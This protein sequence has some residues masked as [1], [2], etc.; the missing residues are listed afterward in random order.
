ML[1]GVL[2]P[3]VGKRGGEVR[4]A[5]DPDGI[6]VAHV[7]P[8]HV[9]MTIAAFD[10]SLFDSYEVE[11][12]GVFAVETDRLARL[13]KVHRGRGVFA[14]T[15]GPKGELVCR[16][17]FLT[18]SMR[19]VEPSTV[20]DPKVPTVEPTARADGLDPEAV[21]REVKAAGSVARDAAI[22]RNREGVTILAEGET[23][24]ESRAELT[25]AT[26]TGR[27]GSSYP[28]DFLGPV[29]DALKGADGLELGWGKLLP[30]RV[31]FR[32]DREY[33]TGTRTGPMNRRRAVRATKEG[34]I[35]GYYLI[36]PKGG[37]DDETEG[38]RD[39]SGWYDAFM[40]A[41]APVEP[42]L[43]AASVDGVPDDVIR[44]ELARVAEV[45][46][47]AEREYAAEV[48]AQPARLEAYR[49]ALER[50]ETETAEVKARWAVDHPKS[51]KGPSRRWLPS[52]PA[53]PPTEPRQPIP[54]RTFPSRWGNL[55]HET[56]RDDLRELR[57]R[58]PS[59]ISWA[60][61]PIET[62]EPAAEVEI[63]SFRAP[64][65]TPGP[66]SVEAAAETA[67]VEP[68]VEVDGPVDAP[69]EPEPP[70]A[71]TYTPEVAF[72]FARG[73]RPTPDLAPE[74]PEAPEAVPTRENAPERPPARPRRVRQM[75][76]AAPETQEPPAPVEPAP[77]VDSPRMAAFKALPFWEQVARVWP[78]AGPGCAMCGGSGILDTRRHSYTCPS[79]AGP[80]VRLD[81]VPA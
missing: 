52:R 58:N 26:V 1:L 22:F 18:W 54:A 28:L 10:R 74:T 41:R 42:D 44:A 70:F 36:A 60:P 77:Y 35:T 43:S 2:V 47:E 5:V 38:P 46:A 57:G 15:L 64:E 76:R 34:A 12:P 68:T 62:A 45:D 31:S 7:D 14:L 49:A 72:A 37:D 53:G 59:G 32:F 56:D 8:S 48:A 9:A 63:A 24:Q 80:V 50:W 27:G 19:T 3:T 11:R 61:K 78:K 30:L 16:S 67:A 65:P 39:Y 4:L 21:A 33:E 69:S 29:A 51:R 23:G 81:G 73:A 25:A 66:G 13:L 17:G 6:R 55:P 40:R 75:R 20:T 71:G 79:C